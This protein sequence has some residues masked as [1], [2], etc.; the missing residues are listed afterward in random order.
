MDAVSD[1]QEEEKHAINTTLLPPSMEGNPED[2]QLVR[3]PLTR[4]LVLTE[5]SAERSILDP[6]SRDD[7]KF[8]E[9]QK[10]LIDWINDELEDERIIVKNLE[11]DLYDGQVLQKLFGEC[12]KKS[13]NV[14]SSTPEKLSGWRLNVAEVT[15]SEAGQKQK[16]QMVLG[17]ANQLLRPHGWDIDWSVDSIHSKNLVAIMSL[18]VGLAMHFQAPIRLPEHVSVQ[19]VLVK[20]REGSL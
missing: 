3:L 11:E 20:V 10:R 6:S 8:K 14:P 2:S 7:P 9:L 1:L 17:A 4:R 13:L 5:E 15:Q 19:L 12:G 18:L 16:L